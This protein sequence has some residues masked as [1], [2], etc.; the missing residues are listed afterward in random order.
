[1]PIIRVDDDVYQALK[2]RAEPLKSTPNSVMRQVFGLDDETVKQWSYQARLRRLGQ[3]L[4]RTGRVTKEVRKE[5]A[6]IRNS[7]RT[8]AFGGK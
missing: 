2:D 3:A 4:S 7:F 5:L 1:M 8:G 6:D